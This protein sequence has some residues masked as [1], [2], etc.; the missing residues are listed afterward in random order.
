M[1]VAAR[2]SGLDPFAGV[3]SPRQLVLLGAF[4]PRFVRILTL[5]VVR[6]RPNSLIYRHSSQQKGRGVRGVRALAAW[7]IALSLALA[8][9]SGGD[10]QA[11]G[12]G[13]SGPPATSSSTSAAPQHDGPPQL[14]SLAR[15][16]SNA[17]AKAFVRYYIDVLNYADASGD[18]APL[19]DAAT[20]QC[21]ICKI[22]STAVEEIA[23]SGG[24][25]IGGEWIL[26]EVR[27]LPHSGNQANMLVGI[28][29]RVGITRRTRESPPHRSGPTNVTYEFQLRWERRLW[30]MHD[31]RAG[32]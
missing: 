20:P 8:G 19:R 11:G 31:L 3:S 13:P 21:Q 6:F 14:P 25:Q 22:L 18:P 32:G 26:R 30:L 5:R 16:H 7:G 28:H 12:S 27:T 24:T 4:A 2:S 23:R 1:L 10:E 17:G 29:I 15:E 9:C